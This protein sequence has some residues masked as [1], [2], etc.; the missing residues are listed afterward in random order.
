MA[1][2][3]PNLIQVLQHDN[4]ALRKQA[5]ERLK[6]AATEGTVLQLLEALRDEKFWVRARAAEALG[7]VG[8]EMATP[9]L[10]GSNH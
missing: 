7:Y 5:V 3:E 9:S 10:F 6:H 1:P 4:P 8:A 2:N